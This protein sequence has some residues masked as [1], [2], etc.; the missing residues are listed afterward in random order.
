MKEVHLPARI[1][2]GFAQE[3]SGEVEIWAREIASQGATC[4][5]AKCR[6]LNSSAKSCL[7]SVKR[8][9]GAAEKLV[10]LGNDTVVLALLVECNRSP[11]GQSFF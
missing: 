8:P 2:E 6:A 9:P 4:K 3:H 5:R 7:A 1:A 10:E 11:R